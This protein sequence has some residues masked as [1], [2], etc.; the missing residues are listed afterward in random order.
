MRMPCPAATSSYLLCGSVRTPAPPKSSE[1]QAR[2]RRERNTCLRYSRFLMYEEPRS[3]PVPY[4][5]RLLGIG[6][7]LCIMLEV[8]FREFLLGVNQ[9]G[10]LQG[11]EAILAPLG[12]GSM[13]DPGYGLRRILL[14]RTRVNR[15]RWRRTGVFVLDKNSGPPFRQGESLLL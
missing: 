12:E 5:R 9:C 10:P 8:N 7:G 13:H 2:Q 4:V 15:A 14:L 3:V 11:L 6:P 1:A